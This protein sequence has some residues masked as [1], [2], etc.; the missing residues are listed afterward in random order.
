[1]TKRIEICRENISQ[2][3]IFFF[4]AREHQ[5]N[6][7]CNTYITASAAFVR[8]NSFG[9]SWTLRNCDWHSRHTSTSVCEDKENP[10]GERKIAGSDK[11]E[12][13]WK[14]QTGNWQHLFPKLDTIIRCKVQK[15]RYNNERTVL[16][17]L[18]FSPPFQY[19]SG[20][21]FSRRR[22]KSRVRRRSRD[23]NS[24]TSKFPFSEPT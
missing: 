18:L 5:W 21:P 3:R 11:G 7:V 24:K 13:S 16:S 17:I 4:S 6:R 8:H 9:N 20:P 12:V 1:M 10:R 2:I 22:W 19:Q 15:A 14:L 23:N